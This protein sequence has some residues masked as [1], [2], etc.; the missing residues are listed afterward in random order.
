MTR[1]KWCNLKNQKYIDVTE[2]N[3]KYTGVTTENNLIEENNLTEE[4]QSKVSAFV[5]EIIK[6]YNPNN[7][8]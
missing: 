6:R 3:Q 2:E 1:C 5:E 7:P 8:Y 4:Q